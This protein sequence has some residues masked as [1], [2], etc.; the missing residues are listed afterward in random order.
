[1]SAESQFEC[2]PNFSEGRRTDVLDAIREA[3]RVP[4]V[5]VLGLDHD[6]DHNRAVL[7]LLGPAD[8]LVEAVFGAMRVAVERIDLRSH[9]GAHPRMGAAD[10]V[11]F[12][13]WRH[14]T[15]QSA[16]MLARQLAERVGRELELPVYL[17]G[18]AAAQVQRTHLAEVRRGEF[19][20]LA[21]R[22]PLEPP[23]YGPAHPHLTAG[24]VAIGARPVLIAFNVYLQTDDLRVARAVARAVRGSSGGLVG[25][26]AL[27]MD[28]RS[29]GRVQVSM[30]LV[31]YQRTSMPRALEMVR[32]EAARFGVTVAQ[33]ELVGLM[34][35][36]AAAQAL[37]YYLQMPDFGR[38]R[39]LEAARDEWD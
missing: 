12:V 16:V 9:R 34:P 29:R 10:V 21:A 15:M 33:T 18:E 28:T 6:R 37:Q 39:V 30:N 25:V 1:M 8:A 35:F 20:G 32:Q 31:D 14:A 11:P 2:V 5:H 36:A 19:E 22:M 7:T 13:P 3:A 26:K 4:E 17:Y 38:S 24:A 27:A 23:D